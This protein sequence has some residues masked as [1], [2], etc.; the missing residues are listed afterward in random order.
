LPSETHAFTALDDDKGERVDRFLAARISSLSRS[1]VKALIEEGRLT[2]DGAAVPD[3]SQPVRSGA[4]Y[5]LEE[6]PSRPAA[7]QAERI[8]LDILFE[9][10]HLIVL[11]KAAGLVVHPAPGHA[12]GTLVNAILGHAGDEMEGIGGEARPGIV[13]RLDK[14]T[15]GIMVVAK[16]QVAHTGLSQ[17]FHDRDL[18]RHYLALAWGIPMPAE[19]VIEGAIGRHGV[20]RKRMAVVTRGGK[21][22]LTRYATLETIHGACA[23][24]RCRLD[25]GRT[26]Q[27]RVHLAHAGHPLVGDPVY[28]RRIPASSRQFSETA[29]GAALSFPRQALHAASLRFRHPVTG[30][31]LSFS[32][33]P[34]ADF[35]A[36]LAALR[37]L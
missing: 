8:P 20:D 33:E 15:S 12:G 2:R 36:L 25:T 21:P 23:L 30:V 24:L 17:A 9:D 19:G 31:D 6:P 28:L 26:H 37:T 7:P 3:P 22:A 32:S 34:P 27:I 5:R 18:D 11:D 1:R 10:R 14:D 29:R 13:H 4:T 16:S 35:Q